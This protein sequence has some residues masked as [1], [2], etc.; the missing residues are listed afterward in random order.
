MYIG[1]QL[2]K[3]DTVEDEPKTTSKNKVMLLRMSIRMRV[4]CLSCKGVYMRIVNEKNRGSKMHSSTLD[5]HP[6]ARY[7]L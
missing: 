4:S 3:L 6:M 2:I 7:V 1:D 5:A